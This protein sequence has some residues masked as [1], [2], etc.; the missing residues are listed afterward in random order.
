MRPRILGG[1]TDNEDIKNVIPEPV[2]TPPPKIRQ[3]PFDYDGEV[4]IGTQTEERREDEFPEEEEEEEEVEDNQLNPRGDVFSK[5]PF[6]LLPCSNSVSGIPGGP[7]CINHKQ[8]K[9]TQLFS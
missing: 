9:Q 4:Y 1:K 7:Q 6:V 8:T 2:A 3:Q 5:W